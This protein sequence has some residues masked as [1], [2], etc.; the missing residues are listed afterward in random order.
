M[1]NMS[2]MYKFV[3]LCY[4][5]VKEKT[6]R[7]H[8]R[9]QGNKA[10]G[11]DLTDKQIEAGEKNVCLMRWTKGAVEALHEGTESVHDRADGGCQLVGHTCKK[12]HSPMKGHTVGTPHK[13]GGELGCEGLQFVGGE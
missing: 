7:E 13:G 6:Y 4:R 8:N 12:N 11:H 3:V 9:R 2:D 10:E 1:L 5:L